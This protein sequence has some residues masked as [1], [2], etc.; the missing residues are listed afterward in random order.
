LSLA[1]L[2]LLACRTDVHITLGIVGEVVNTEEPGAVIHISNGDVGTDALL[3]DG[4]Q[5]FF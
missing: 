2:Q 3:F 1:K 4:D 5:I